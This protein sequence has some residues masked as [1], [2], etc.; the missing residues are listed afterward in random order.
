M[1]QH[2]G[3]ALLYTSRFFK[4]T[5]DRIGKPTKP[6]KLNQMTRFVGYE[7]YFRGTGS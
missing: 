4:M 1:P 5:R 7:G 2:S 3:L 6:S